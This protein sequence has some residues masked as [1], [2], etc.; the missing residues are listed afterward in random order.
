M[1]AFVCMQ[2]LQ[3]IT[4]IQTKVLRMNAPCV[5]QQGEILHLKKLGKGYHVRLNILD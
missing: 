2:N 5:T 3:L 1:A 4:L